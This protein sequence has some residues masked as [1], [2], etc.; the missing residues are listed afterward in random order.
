MIIKKCEI[1]NKSFQADANKRKYCS[2]ECYHK[3]P[4]WNKGK[5]GL[6][7]A[8][9]KTDILRKCEYCENDFKI[10]PSR[11][12]VARFCSR[13]CQN[14]WIGKNKRKYGN[15]NPN[16]KNGIMIYRRE[17][18]RLLGNT[19]NRCGSDNNIVVHHKDENRNNNPLDGSN[20]EILCKR[21]HQLHHNCIDKLPKN[22]MSPLRHLAGEMK[23][24]NPVVC[25][26]CNKEYYR[27]AGHTKQKFCSRKCYF[28][29]RY[30]RFT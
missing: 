25:I 27:F 14:K 21:C 20:W 9:N 13:S 28:D 22:K 16:Y 10:T 26:Q 2:Q 7:E 17:A 24:L 11:L 30:N 8:W 19:C 23:L 5:K 12:E 1:C 18:H 6:Q 15:E 3:R 29:N 4:V